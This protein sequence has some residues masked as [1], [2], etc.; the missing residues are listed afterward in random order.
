MGNIQIISIKKDE[1]PPVD[2]R[3]NLEQEIEVESTAAPVNKSTQSKA[4]KD[5]AERQELRDE[6]TYKGLYHHIQE[7]RA[8]RQSEEDRGDKR[9]AA[10]ATP[11]RKD[12][13]VG[14]NEMCPCG[15]GKKFKFCHGYK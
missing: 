1:S 9:R 10:A 15:S 12:P 7:L 13:K 4:T 2:L 11:A 8:K 14:R 6:S 5:E 3:V